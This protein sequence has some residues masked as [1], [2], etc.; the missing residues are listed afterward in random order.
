MKDKKQSTSSGAFAK[1]GNTKMRGPQ[2]V[3]PSEPGVSVNPN[4]PADNKFGIPSG[5]GKSG[6]MGKQRGAAPAE[7]GKASPGGRQGNN[8]FSVKGGTGHMAGFTG[9]TPARAQ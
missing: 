9:S 2:S 7:P 4:K 6:V 3:N 5:V 1:G 8:D